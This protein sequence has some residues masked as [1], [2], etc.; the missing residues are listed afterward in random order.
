MAAMDDSIPDMEGEEIMEKRTYAICEVMEELKPC[1]FCGGEPEKMTSSD[2]FTSIGCLRCNPVFGVMVQRMTEAEAIAAW[3]ARA[4]R[5]CKNDKDKWSRLAKYLFVCS[6]CGWNLA[7][8]GN[9]A[10]DI[11]ARLMKRCPFCGARLEEV[12]E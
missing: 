10:I 5:T 8:V 11:S 4:E 1:P 9:D 7:D 3:N 6:E 12:G 2:G